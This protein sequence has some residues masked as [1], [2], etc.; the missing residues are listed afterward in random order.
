MAKACSSC[1]GTIN[2]IEFMVC[3]GICG[4]EF[5]LTCVSVS[6]AAARSLKSLSKN[7]FWMCDDCAGLFENAHFRSLAFAPPPEKN[8]ITQL[9][10]AISEL[11]SEIKQACA[12]PPP[13]PIPTLTPA[14]PDYRRALKRFRAP[15]A[16]ISE[17]C[18]L[19]AKRSSSDVVSVPMCSNEKDNLF[20]LY[21]S[22][23][24]PDVSED[25]VASM[26]KA[27]LQTDTMQVVKL[28]SKGTD[29]STM[30]FVSFKVGVDLELKDMALDPE[31]WPNG[32]SFREFVNYDR[33]NQ[34]RPRFQ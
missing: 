20:W 9:T 23:I 15:D 3:R 19:G 34:F 27:N 18:K 28:V 10:E 7:A 5:H 16:P 1:C 32:L 12:K 30:R 24:K 26:V 29:T 33:N 6:N 11:R 8:G 2:G 17:P 21:I 22:R 31:T 25:D 4:K 14:R 13:T